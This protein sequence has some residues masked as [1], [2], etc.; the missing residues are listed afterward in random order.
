MEAREEVIEVLNNAI[1]CATDD[2]TVS[3]LEEAK[4]C[5]EYCHTN[6][7]AM[8]VVLNKYDN[9]MI[10]PHCGKVIGNTAD[11]TPN[12]CYECGKPLSGGNGK[13]K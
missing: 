6:T 12:Y 4:R 8:D 9:L 5:V 1:G 10:C 3:C 13:A 7:V 11:W 2:D